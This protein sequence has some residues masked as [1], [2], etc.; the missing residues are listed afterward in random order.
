MEP[1][2]TYDSEASSDNYNAELK[3]LS[4]ATKLTVFTVTLS[5]GLGGSAQ[6]ERSLFPIQGYGI[7]S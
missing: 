2:L 6:L 4:G 3:A 7:N 1:T 5:D